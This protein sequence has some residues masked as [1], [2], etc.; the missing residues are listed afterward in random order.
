M[1]SKELYH[2]TFPPAMCDG[3]NSSISPPTLAIVSFLITVILEEYRDIG[4]NNG[5]GSHPECVDWALC[6]KA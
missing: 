1:F 4:G 2:F 5:I 6:G 3:A